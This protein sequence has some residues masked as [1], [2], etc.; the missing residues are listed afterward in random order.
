MGVQIVPHLSQHMKITESVWSPKQNVA[1]FRYLSRSIV[2]DPRSVKRV[3][4]LVA[5]LKSIIYGALLLWVLAHVREVVGGVWVRTRERH[6]MPYIFQLDHTPSL[7]WS[8]T[9]QP[10]VP[11][12]II[13]SLDAQETAPDS[14]FLEGSSKQ[15]RSWTNAPQSE[16]KYFH[17]FHWVLYQYLST[18]MLRKSNLCTACVPEVH[19]GICTAVNMNDDWKRGQA[20]VILYV[21]IQRFEAKLFTAL[22]IESYKTI[23][24]AP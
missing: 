2:P 18:E 23:Y 11:W 13:S 7:D 22:H 20:W 12:S 17:Q 14:C 15:L 9:F 1:S 4:A 21:F 6:F 8:H 5:C 24:L 16:Y 19:V 3:N 10:R